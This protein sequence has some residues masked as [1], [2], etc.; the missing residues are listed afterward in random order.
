M[1]KISLI[2][3][4]TLSLQ[5]DQFSLLFYND[6]FARTDHH[7]TNG[8]GFSW[9]D[10][11]FE[12]ENEGNLTAYSRWMY[13]LADTVS[14]GAMDGSRKHTAGIGLS[15][16][17][18]TPDDLTQSV[19]QYDDVPYAGYLALSFY[20]FEWDNA[21]FTEYRMEAGV[22]GEESGAGWV[23]RTMHKIVGDTKPEGWDTQLG[24]EWI[25]NVLYR[26]GYKS[27][28]RHNSNGLSM[29][30]FNHFGLQAGNYTTDAFAGTVFRLGQNYVE[31]FNVAY[32]YLKEEAA[33]LRSYG[34]H[35]GF[36]WSLSVGVNGELLLYSYLFEESQKEGYALDDN[37]FNISPYAGLSL[38]YDDYKL[39]FFYQAQSYTLNGE[40]ELDAF[41]GFRLGYQF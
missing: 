29:D 3:L 20:L 11:T 12:H 36:G 8:L 30:W 19:P 16:I 32:P 1:K 13:D 35:H 18:I 24:T 37:T 2:L 17:I 40:Y 26:Q 23:Q 34:K 7:F 5:A 28:T 41:G 14:F 39:T 22:V 4:L 6:T 21:S 38:Y 25:F 9:L 27:W 15:Q 10:D 33:S 31:N